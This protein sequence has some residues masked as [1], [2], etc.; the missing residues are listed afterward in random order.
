MLREAGETRLDSPVVR[1]SLIR[2]GLVVAALLAGAWL[3]FS[4]HA[5]MLQEEGEA[6]LDRAGRVPVQPAEVER[7]QDAFRGARWLSADQEPLVDEGL[8]MATA[9]R[10]AEAG[11]L[12]ELATQREPE[13]SR[14]W[15]LALAS[16]PDREH[17]ER[18]R[19][20]LRE[21]NPWWASLL[22]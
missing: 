14:A 10:T 1:S 13:N 8:L 15:F 2:S 22:R 6:V 18:A 17:A 4:Y 12:A 9:G 21:L 5:V 20:R 11:D 3:V 7:A 16:A 19:R